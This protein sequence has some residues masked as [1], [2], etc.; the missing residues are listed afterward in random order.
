M[1]TSRPIVLAVALGVIGGELAAAAL[2]PSVSPVSAV[3]SFVID[4]LPPG[5]KDWA[6]AWFGTA[7]KTVFLLTIGVLIGVLA[8]AAGTEPASRHHVLP[9]HLVVR[10]STGPA[11]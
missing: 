1:V 10:K 7:D 9:V 8:L 6:I 5:V 4:V 2:S 3:G 11:R